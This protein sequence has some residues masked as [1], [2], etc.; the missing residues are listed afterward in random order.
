[1]ILKSVS[2]DLVDAK[3][4]SGDVDLVS[5]NMFE[6]LILVPLEVAHQSVIKD[7]SL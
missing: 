6:V 3:G 4:N 1:M 7:S 2:D 5:R